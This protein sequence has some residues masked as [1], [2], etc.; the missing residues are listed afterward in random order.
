MKNIPKEVWVGWI[1]SL[2]EA[3]NMAI[4]NF[5]A[6]FLATLIF[7]QNSHSVFFSYGLVF[8]GSCFLY[9]IGGIYYGFIGDRKGRRETCIYS[10]LGLGIVTGCMGLVPYS[11]VYFLILICAAHFFSGGEYHGS[12]VFSLEHSEGKQKG[13]MSALSCLF[14]VFGLMAASCFSTIAITLKSAFCIQ[15]CFFVGALGGV[16]SYW[17]KNHCAETPAFIGISQTSFAARPEW[18]KILR[19]IGVLAFF[20]VS[21]SFIFVFLPLMQFKSMHHFDTFKSLILYGLFLVL[22]GFFADLVGLKRIM[23]VGTILFAITLIPLACFCKNLLLFQMVLTPA[24]CL[25]IGPLHSWMLDQFEVQNRCRGIFIGS[26]IATAIFG[27]STVPIC[28]LIFETTHSLA[29]CCLYPLIVAL[30]ALSC[31]I[32]ETRKEVLA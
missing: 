20:I 19:I 2:V 28:L 32:I 23:M 29:I 30:S 4:Y 24:A 26:A 25:V 17:L 3:Y 8:I 11:W 22:A 14:A 7:K 16:I 31:L 12:I 27:G 21:Y 18:A 9:P 15:I 1:S 13:V 10:T 6:P 5:V